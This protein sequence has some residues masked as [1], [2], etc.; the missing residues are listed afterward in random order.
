MQEK[1]FLGFRAISSLYFRSPNFC[2]SQHFG[3]SFENCRTCLRNKMSNVTVLNINK[4]LSSHPFKPQPAMHRSCAMTSERGRGIP[5]LEVTVQIG[6]A[7]TAIGQ[8]H[9][10][11]SCSFPVFFLPQVDDISKIISHRK[12]T[13]FL[14]PVLL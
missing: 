2:F 11:F 13:G 14:L 1:I 3:A 4:V 10:D 7:S 5:F 6:E 9:Q 12:I 8:I